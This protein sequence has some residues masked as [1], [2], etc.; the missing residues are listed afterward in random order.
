MTQ[1]LTIVGLGGSLARSSRSLAAL[2]V[3]LEGAAEAGAST[4]LLDLRELDLPMYNPD[5]ERE[6]PPAALIRPI[7]SSCR[8]GGSRE[9]RAWSQSSAFLNAPEIVPWYIGL[10]HSIPSAP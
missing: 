3:A 4:Q 7:T 5:D 1:P 2:R 8:N 10:L 9:P 6:A